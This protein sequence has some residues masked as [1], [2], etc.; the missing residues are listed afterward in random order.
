MKKKVL[1]FLM[2]F[3]MFFLGAYEYKGISNINLERTPWQI[4]DGNVE[5]YWS[6]KQGEQCG[7]LEIICNQPEK[8]EA[9]Y[10][11]CEIPEEAEIQ[12]YEKN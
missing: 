10:I 1:I 3:C 5:T 4:I 9:V 6:T 8:K 7:W 11:D 2:T 12:L